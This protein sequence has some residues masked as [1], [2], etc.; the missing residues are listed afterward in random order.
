[1]GEGQCNQGTK[2]LT[3]RIWRE[4]EFGMQVGEI[5][6]IWAM[7]SLGHRWEKWEGF[8]GK[9]F[10]RQVANADC[11]MRARGGL[12]LRGGNP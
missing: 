7:R 4:K 5:G 12:T 9:G 11:K 2:D 10:A 3:G 1:M 6:R 8:G